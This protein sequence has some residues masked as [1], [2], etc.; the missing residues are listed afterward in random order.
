ML[1]WVVGEGPSYPILWSG[2]LP[3]L[4]LRARLQWSPI[5]LGGGAAFDFQRLLVVDRS[6]LDFDWSSLSGVTLESLLWL[7]G[8]QVYLVIIVTV[9]CLKS[10]FCVCLLLHH[11]SILFLRNR[12]ELLTNAPWPFAG[13]V[14][15]G[16]HH[17]DLCSGTQWM[18]PAYPGQYLGYWGPHYWTR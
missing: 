3:W 2:L 15:P 8:A 5:S 7:K 14:L 11:H 1:G 10:A 4:P 9:D 16:Y 12:E 17:E 18:L 13:I 6:S